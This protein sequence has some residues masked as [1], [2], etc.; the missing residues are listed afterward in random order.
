MGCIPHHQNS[1]SL[2]EELENKRESLA[3]AASIGQ[4]KE[5]IGVEISVE[6]IKKL[7]AK[8]VEKYHLR[9]QA[10]SRKQM[11]GGLVESTCVK[12]R[13]PTFFQ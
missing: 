2:E 13:S 3:I 7:S 8:D 12:K 5:H 11:A 1:D 6:D 4:I 10:V 9:A